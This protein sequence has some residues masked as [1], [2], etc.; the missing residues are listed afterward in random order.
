MSI[1]VNNIG[2]N[3]ATD[4]RTIHINISPP[5]AQQQ[6]EQ[7]ADIT[8]TAAD[9]SRELENINKQV[10]KLQD[11]SNILGRKLV[12]NVNKDLGKVV[13][14]IVDPET[15]KVIKEIPSADIQKLQIRIKETLGLLIDEKI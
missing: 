14:K 9:V 13:V 5:A 7:K 8:Q 15:D 10:A 6:A 12:F 1:A 4:G 11:I 2:H 3:S